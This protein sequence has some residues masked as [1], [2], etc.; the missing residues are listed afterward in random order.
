M[1][2]AV[3]QLLQRFA[4]NQRRA[5]RLLMVP[6]SS[7]RHQ[8]CHPDAHQNEG[9][10][11]GRIVKPSHADRFPILEV[12]NCLC[13]AIGRTL[14]CG[15]AAAT[16]HSTLKDCSCGLPPPFLPAGKGGSFS[17]CSREADACNWGGARPV[18]LHGWDDMRSSL[19]LRLLLPVIG[20]AAV[21]CCQ[22]STL[23]LLKLAADLNDQGE[24]RRALDLVGPLI[25]SN[26]IDSNHVKGEPAQVGVAWN[27][28]GLA[29]QNLGEID[30][31]RRSYET[32]IGILRT[33]PALRTQYASTLAN[34]GSLDADV[35]QLSE[36]RRLRSKAKELYEA[37]KDHSGVARAWTNL[38]LVSL[39]QGKK[40]EARHSLSEAFREESLV[41]S[42]DKRDLAWMYSAECL[43]QE[44]D[45]DLPGALT[46]VDRAIGLWIE[47]YGS[48]YYL[49]A[50]GYSLRGGIYLSRGQYAPAGDDLQHSLNVL[51]ANRQSDSE[52][53][54]LTEIAY[55]KALHGSG[56]NADASRLDG[57]ARAALDRLRSRQCA[58]CTVSADAFR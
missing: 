30:K 45:G 23:G 3:E 41:S 40:R 55:A 44:K 56:M 32:A 39:G 5:C 58:T 29:L 46:S 17:D 16:E 6:V 2:A 20:S 4:F 31:A 11:C 43:I 13:I 18:N 14:S 28:R 57:E 38:A 35:G 53:Y 33:I 25:D 48:G 52:T 21:A 24:F 51:A 15:F 12:D 26:P 42:Q 19:L 7:F 8:A 9:P 49:L 47:R 37:A 22:D 34:L 27:I 1:K 54:F 36:S 50:L 10:A